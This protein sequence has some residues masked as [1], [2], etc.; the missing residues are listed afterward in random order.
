MNIPRPRVVLGTGI[1]KTSRSAGWQCAFFPIPLVLPHGPAAPIP[2]GADTMRIFTPRRVALTSLVIAAAATGAYFA[3]RPNQPAVA[4]APQPPAALLLVDPRPAGLL[5]GSAVMTP[6]E[7]ESYRK[8]QAALVKNEFVTNAAL[9]DPKARELEVVRQQPDAATWLAEHLVVEYGENSAV[10]RISVTGVPPMEAAILANAVAQAFRNE[11]V[12]QDIQVLRERQK[13]VEDAQGE[14]TRALETRKQA[15][16]Q[17][18]SDVGVP[19]NAADHRALIA[20]LYQERSG[21]K[22]ELAKLRVEKDACPEPGAREK[23]LRDELTALDARIK[24]CEQ[25]DLDAMRA[26]VARLEVAISALAAEHTRLHL[27]MN[28]PHRVTLL[29][30]APVAGN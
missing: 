26:D 29:A 17:L 8:T 28:S 20:S 23:V 22:V 11:A 4:T 7:I 24:S 5:P 14:L 10:L 19:P 21:L 9:R 6:G 27:D 30:L 12:Q 25:A 15:L 16:N 2:S 3:F 18:A 1:A 13:K